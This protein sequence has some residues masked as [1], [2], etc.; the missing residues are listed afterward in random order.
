V[1]RRGLLIG[2]DGDTDITIGDPTVSRRHCHIFLIADEV[3]IEYL[4]SR[5]PVLVNGSPVQEAVLLVGDEV[6]VGGAR[7]LLTQ[8]AAGDPER[9][10]TSD[11]PE[12]RSWV[13][14]EYVSVPVDAA[15]ENARVR[16]HSIHDLVWLHDFARELSGCAT[17]D[18]LAA[19]LRVRLH[20]RFQPTEL[21]IARV[22]GGD[23]LDFLPSQE[24]DPQSA[25]LEVICRALDEQRGLLV[26]SGREARG[27]ILVVPVCL[28]NVNVA[29]VALHRSMPDGAY[30]DEDLRMLVV[31]GQVLAPIL[32]ALEGTAK[33]RAADGAS[34]EDASGAP[35][36]V[37]KSKA[38]RR[39]RGQI[40]EAAK[41]DL[42]VLITGETGTG[43][44]LAVR[45][46]HARSD[47]SVVPLVT[48]NCASIPRDLFPSVLFG[49]TKGAFTGA[50]A[51]SDGLLQHADRG[52][53]FLDEI[54]ELGLDNQAALLRV[55]ETG[56]FR[57]VGAEEERRVDVRVVA[58]TNTNIVH[59]IERG[60]FRRD[61]YHRINGFEIHIP[62]LR[63]RPSDVLPLAAHFFEIDRARARGPLRGIAPEAMEYLC[64]RPWPGNV[65]ELR[66]CV[67][68]A[69]ASARHDMIQQDDLH[70]P[71]DAAVGHC[72]EDV[73]LTLSEV[74][75]RHITAV[76]ERCGGN[77]THAARALKIGR[78]TLYSK[79]AEH[80][81]RA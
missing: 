2:R 52:I 56:M 32:C 26:A 64:S 50:D 29:V 9:P 38:I 69:I 61:L 78:T 59:A 20:Q 23:E 21:W 34:Q 73:L 66:N 70:E 67:L 3:R 41:S 4:G 58:A 6:S 72:T 39:V 54:G 43:K 46:L 7:F 74:E 65:R 11:V 13:E 18:A 44:E 28:G 63:E 42:N 19:A 77:V 1:G 8:A 24:Q 47:R 16:P 35:I 31:T 22:H 5:N 48:V 80:G 12:T 71:G 45:M 60:T 75:K 62:P 15:N 27:F 25:P 76:L 37:G 30:D 57:R 51:A 81:L 49:H 55:I 68:R 40:A 79:I 17:E 14:A 33:T 53:L 10:A 36:L